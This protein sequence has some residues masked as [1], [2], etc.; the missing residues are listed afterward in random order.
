[1]QGNP[2][3]IG[4]P[5]RVRGTGEGDI[6]RIFLFNADN[7]GLTV[8]D[9]IRAGFLVWLK[10]FPGWHFSR[11]SG[12]G[13][14]MSILDSGN[15]G[16]GTAGPTVK[17][18][19]ADDTA[20]RVGSAYLSSGSDGQYMHLGNASWYAGPGGWRFPG[21]DGALLQF[22]GQT[23]AFYKPT[24]GVFYPQMSVTPSGNVGIG[25]TAPAAK[26]HVAGTIIQDPG[27]R[28]PPEDGRYRGQ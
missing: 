6:N 1:V 4:F 12:T 10:S 11:D 3:D 20:I 16:I 15:V 24:G 25:T 22:T 18:E 27:L 21:G 19:V 23:I 8:H 2:A 7:L 26:L 17:L 13:I 9:S 28:S 5:F 14:A